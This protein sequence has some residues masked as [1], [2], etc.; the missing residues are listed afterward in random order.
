MTTKPTPTAEA[1]ELLRQAEKLYKSYVELAV[2]AKQSRDMS[3]TDSIVV[4]ADTPLT[5]VVNS[6]P[7]HAL[8][9]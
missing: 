9:E 7:S 4:H 2:L 6:G 3:A 5:L 8:V 1:E